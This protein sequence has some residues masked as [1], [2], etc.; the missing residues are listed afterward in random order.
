MFP[1][2]ALLTILLAGAQGQLQI[3]SSNGT[4]LSSVRVI[5][6]TDDNFPLNLTGVLLPVDVYSAYNESTIG[7]A[8]EVSEFC[9]SPDNQVIFLWVDQW[10]SNENSLLSNTSQKPLAYPRVKGVI[11]P[12]PFNGLHFVK[13]Q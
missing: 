7:D 4:L 12:M 2:L 5:S 11:T 13:E 3:L 9:V 10:L 6:W 1:L 8:P